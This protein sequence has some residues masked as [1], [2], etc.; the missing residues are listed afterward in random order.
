MEDIV[1]SV[2]VFLGTVNLVDEYFGKCSGRT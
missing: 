1:E 2:V